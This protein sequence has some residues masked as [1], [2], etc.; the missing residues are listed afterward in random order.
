M[1]SSAHTTLIDLEI[2]NEIAFI[3]DA[4]ILQCTQSSVD[5]E[6]VNE[7]RVAADSE[8]INENYVAA[9]SEIISDGGVVSSFIFF[10][11]CLHNI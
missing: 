3:A 1:D 8:I 6:I 7:N 2:I 10:V 11:G 5:L 4:W 9:D